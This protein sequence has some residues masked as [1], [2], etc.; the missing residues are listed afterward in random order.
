MASLFCIS[1]VICALYWTI[2][3]S[4]LSEQINVLEANEKITQSEIGSLRHLINLVI[5]GDQRNDK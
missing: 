2:S 4:S 5:L 1:F 3:V